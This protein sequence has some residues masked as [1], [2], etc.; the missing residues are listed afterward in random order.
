MW[1]SGK[2]IARFWEHA[3]K[4]IFLKSVAESPFNVPFDGV[5][6][7][8]CDH[9]VRCCRPHSSSHVCCAAL[10]SCSRRSSARC[11]LSPCM[12]HHLVGFS[13]GDPCCCVRCAP[14]RRAAQHDFFYGARLLRDLLSF[15]VVC[16]MDVYQ[17]AIAAR[18]P[19]PAG[20]QAY[21]CRSANVGR[22]IMCMYV[23]TESVYVLDLYSVHMIHK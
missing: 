15:Q 23:D 6:A 8:G 10:E 9:R 5:F 21:R 1:T 16:A 17:C 18:R 4:H 7:N 2:Q 14:T 11:L 19:C 22:L 13:V 3:E 12:V 20:Q